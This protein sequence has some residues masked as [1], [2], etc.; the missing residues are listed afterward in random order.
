MGNEKYDLEERL[1]QYSARIV[2][3][4]ESLPN[5]R[6]GNHVGG[7]LLRS[8]TSPYFNHGEAQA[9]ESANDFVHKMSICL[10]EL[11]ESYRCLRLIK[12]APL[13]KGTSEVDSLIGE[14]D[15]LIKIFFSSIRTAERGKAKRRKRSD[16]ASSS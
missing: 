10:K 1:L 9:A 8:G 5:T 2:R 3:L 14:T 6:A 16:S 15:E 4:A 11:K 12:A 13:T 7:Q